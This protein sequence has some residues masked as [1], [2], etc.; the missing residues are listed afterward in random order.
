MLSR[1]KISVR[2]VE[3]LPQVERAVENA[4]SI[5]DQI[6]AKMLKIA[7]EVMDEY[8]EALRELAK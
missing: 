4:I 6:R 1:C 2:A 8:D 5:R 3:L 7:D